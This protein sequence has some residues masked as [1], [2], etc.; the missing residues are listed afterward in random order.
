MPAPRLPG[1][2][3]SPIK[4][5]MAIFAGMR[6]AHTGVDRIASRRERGVRHNAFR[7]YYFSLYIGPPRF[8]K[9]MPPLWCKMW[10]LLIFRHIRFLQCRII[11]LPTCSPPASTHPAIRLSASLPAILWGATH[12]W[13]CRSFRYVSVLFPEAA[14]PLWEIYPAYNP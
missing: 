6:T 3:R 8:G 5:R 4:G 10:Q 2:P 12:T 7:F 14:P 13:I 11:S 9:I 1:H